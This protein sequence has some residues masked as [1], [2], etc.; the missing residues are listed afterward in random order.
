MEKYLDRLSE[1]HETL[2]EDFARVK[3]GLWE[4][5]TGKTWN[6]RQEFELKRNGDSQISFERDL[7]LSRTAQR[8]TGATRSLSGER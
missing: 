3:A 7:D 5:Y 6:F 4:R 1:R 8:E 2:R